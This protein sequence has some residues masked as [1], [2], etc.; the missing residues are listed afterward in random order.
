VYIAKGETP[1]QVENPELW[2][3]RSGSKREA[4]AKEHCLSCEERLACLSSTLRFERRQM[5]GNGWV[6]GVQP[7][8]LGG[9][10][11]SE[12]AKILKLSTTTSERDT[13]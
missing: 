10:T 8:V 2:F 11:A 3:G 1:C 9:L 12:R 6:T 4:K 5:A 7:C 13:A